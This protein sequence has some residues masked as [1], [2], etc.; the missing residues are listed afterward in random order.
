MS[1]GTTS[2]KTGMDENLAKQ[3]RRIIGVIA[4]VK[5]DGGS[6]HRGCP[7]FNGVPYSLPPSPPLT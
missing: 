2:V 3:G 7:K 5:R 6:H 1:P 4:R